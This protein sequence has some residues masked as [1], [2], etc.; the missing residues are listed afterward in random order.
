MGKD[1][2]TY[3]YED[4][5]N[6]PA[7]TQ[8]QDSPIVQS[9]YHLL[10]SLGMT[11]VFNKGG[12]TNASMAVGKSIPAV[13]LGGGGTSGGIHTLGEWYDPTD[14][15]KGVQLISALALMIG[16]IADKSESVL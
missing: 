2:I 1:T 10:E 15:Y 12:C 3:K 5:V 6:V 9:T 7:G 13:C 14:S 11:P 4:Y 16:G 8:P